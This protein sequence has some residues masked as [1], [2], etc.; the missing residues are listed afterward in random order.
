MPSSVA[1]GLTAFALGAAILPQ[2]SARPIVLTGVACAVLLDIDAIGRPFGYGDLAWFG[3]HRALTHSTFFALTLGLGLTFLWR[4]RLPSRALQGRAAA[5]LILAMVA[6]GVFDAFTGYGDGVALFAPLSWHRF[7]SAW[8]P[9]A[10]VWE[11]VFIVWL[12]AGLFLGY[13]KRKRAP[14]PDS[15]ARVA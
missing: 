9:F 13:I 12:P 4:Q 2:R 3:G 6:H 10:G 14:G 8:E 5:F 1:H 11:E 7:A 15:T